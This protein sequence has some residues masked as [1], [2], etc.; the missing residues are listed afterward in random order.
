MSQ[1]IYHHHHH[2][3]IVVDTVIVIINTGVSHYTPVQFMRFRIYTSWK[4]I[5]IKRIVQ[6]TKRT[7]MYVVFAHAKAK[8]VQFTTR[9][10][11]QLYTIF[12]CT[13]AKFSF[14]A[15]LGL[16]GTFRNITPCITENSLH[17]I[18]FF[19]FFFFAPSQLLQAGT[20]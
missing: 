10:V 6:F 8:I 5:N 11:I 19:F 18:F 9:T 20:L 15:I 4:I 17:L 2:L 16:H 7:Q 12:G 3:T 1:D 14:Y 13:Q